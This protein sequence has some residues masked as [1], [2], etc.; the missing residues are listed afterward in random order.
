MQVEKG[1]RGV[2][3][4]VDDDGRSPPGGRPATP[5]REER[6]HDPSSPDARRRRGRTPRRARSARRGTGR[7]RS[8]GSSETPP[9]PRRGSRT[10]VPSPDVLQ[11]RLRK[12]VI[13]S[14]GH[15]T[16]DARTRAGRSSRRARDQRSRFGPE[17]CQLLPEN[18]DGVV[19][20]DVLMLQTIGQFVAAQRQRVD[21][22]DDIGDDLAIDAAGTGSRCV[23]PRGCPAAPG[24]GLSGG[25]IR[26]SHS[27]AA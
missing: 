7:P 16:P 27:R 9:R 24:D 21:G 1:E 18:G 14:V 17:T 3:G 25:T 13:V 8:P 6:G 19:E 5:L 26:M 22:P 12:S 11:A 20:D 2:I 10:T 23:A 4:L 15:I